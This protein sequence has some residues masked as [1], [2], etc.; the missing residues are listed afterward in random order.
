MNPEH[1]FPPEATSTRS[2]DED[3]DIDVEELQQQL[4]K[5]EDAALRC[6][7]DL[8]NLQK[9]FQRELARGQEAERRRVL[10]SWTESLDDLE[11]AL[12]HAGDEPNPIA[13]GVRSIVANAVA[14]IAAFGYPRFGS[15]GDQFDP[16]LHQVITTVPAGPGVPANAVVA[17]ITPGYGTLERLLRPASVVVGKGAD[18]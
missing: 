9:R 3:V 18:S 1:A 10:T 14:G 13:D 16:E 5:S 12:A 17:V 11:R 6:A 7:A 8:D 15:P 4:A 2:A